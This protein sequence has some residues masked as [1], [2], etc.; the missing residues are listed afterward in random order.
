MPSNTGLEY[1]TKQKVSAPWTAF[2]SRFAMGFA[3]GARWN[4]CHE[5]EESEA[6]RHGERIW[7]SPLSASFWSI[8]TERSCRGRK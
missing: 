2:G 8:P 5:H 1:G 6:G 3:A 7:L 4:T